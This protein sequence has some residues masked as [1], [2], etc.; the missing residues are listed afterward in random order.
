M[1]ARRVNRTAHTRPIAVLRRE[2]GRTPMA[3]PAVPTKS[4]TGP[5]PAKVNLSLQNDLKFRD[6][7]TLA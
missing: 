7:V 6:R 4:Q 5:R 3:C 1:A 2:K